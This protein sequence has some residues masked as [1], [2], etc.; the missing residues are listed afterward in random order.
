MRMVSML[1]FGLLACLA[2][3]IETVDAS[4][5]QAGLNVKLRVALARIS[6]HFGQPIQIVSGCRSRALNRKVGGRKNSYHLRCMA[7]DIQIKGVSPGRLK[8]FADTIP[9]IG[10]IG[11]YCGRTMIHIDVGPERRWT[12]GCRSRHALK[13]VRKLRLAKK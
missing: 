10:G 2:M 3:P 9:S 11:T 5:K 12:G 4:N 1:G 13:G 6:A 7:A 8:R